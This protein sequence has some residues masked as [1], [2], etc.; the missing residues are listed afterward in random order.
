MPTTRTG[1]ELDE[2]EPLLTKNGTKMEARIFLHLRSLERLFTEH[3]AMEQGLMPAMK[4]LLSCLAA[5]FASRESFSMDPSCDLREH[6]IKLVVA[7]AEQPYRIE[8]GLLL[9]F[10]CDDLSKIAEHGS[11]IKDFKER[12]VRYLRLFADEIK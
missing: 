1:S 6:H 10:L 7:C 8:M 4:L 2:L 12:I 3:L 11:A 9:K 5:Q